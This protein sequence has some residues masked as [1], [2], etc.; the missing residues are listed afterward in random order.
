MVGAAKNAGGAVER[1]AQVRGSA[2]RQSATAERNAPG[3]F[4]I[5]GDVHGCLVELLA[6]MAELGYRVKRRGEVFEVTPP[7]G[8]TLVLVGDLVD[9]GPAAPEVLRLAMGMTRAGTALC[10]AGNRD[11]ELVRALKGRVTQVSR[12]MARSLEQL[13]PQ[14]REFRAEVI[15][16]LRGLPTHLLLDAKRLVIA[17]AGLKEA[18]QGRASAAARAFALHGELTGE[19]D[20]SG[21]P[22]R[23]NW[24]KEYRGNALV[25]HGHTPVAEPMWLGNTVNIDTGCV[26]GGHLTA[27]RYPER[28]TV[29][30]SAR[31]VY[32]TPRRTFAAN[33]ALELR[34]RK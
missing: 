21:L 8:R 13:A 18:L 26:Y 17:H 16:F 19:R 34:A 30:I 28:E 11:V 23:R 31:A 20:A 15:R 10:V 33:K 5:V 32:Y 24:A 1:G 14:P 12:G 29:S 22:I 6:L 25:V 27:L 2:R 4:D 9:R 3:S 7:K